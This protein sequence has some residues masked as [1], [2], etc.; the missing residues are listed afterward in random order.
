MAV[1]EARRRNEEIALGR[2]RLKRKDVPP[3]AKEL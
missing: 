3:A 2:E 1:I